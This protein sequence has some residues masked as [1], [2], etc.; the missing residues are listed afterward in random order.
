MKL[1]RTIDMRTIA[2]LQA[3][4]VLRCP[5]FGSLGVPRNLFKKLTAHA[6]S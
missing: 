5:A 1:F 6:L 3:M 4:L 2:A